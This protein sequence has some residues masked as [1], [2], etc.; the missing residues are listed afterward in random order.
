[1]NL[2]DLSKLAYGNRFTLWH[3]WA[4]YYTV[5]EVSVPGFFNEAC[6]EFSIGDKLEVSAIDGGI[7]F[8]VLGKSVFDG[9]VI[10][11]RWG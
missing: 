11:R 8:F 6:W 2:R 3:Y 1:M 9:T 10:L 4:H 5:E 7:S